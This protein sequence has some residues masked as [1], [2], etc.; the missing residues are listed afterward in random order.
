VLLVSETAGFVIVVVPIKLI[1]TVQTPEEDDEA[2]E[3]EE[4]EEDRAISLAC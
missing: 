2:E 1:G 3:E 4:A